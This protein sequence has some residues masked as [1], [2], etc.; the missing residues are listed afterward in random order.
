MNYL[1]LDGGFCTVLQP[2]V[3]AV[4]HTFPGGEPHIK[5]ALPN[6][7]GK[8]A[9]IT[10]TT[11]LNNSD[12]VMQL[13][14]A[15]DA[16][17]RAGWEHVHAVIPYFPAAR[18]D[19][20]M[21]PGEP[22]SLKVYAGLINA[23]HFASVNVFDPHSEVT[24]AL[25]DRVRA[26]PNHAYAAACLRQISEPY[27]LVSPD[28]GALKKIDKLA[29][30][31]GG[32]HEVVE[33]SKRRDLATGALTDFIVYADD[34]AGRA[35]VVVDDICDGGG[36]FLGL[37]KALRARGAGALYFVVSHGIFSKGLDALAEE[38]AQ[39]FTTDSVRE[40]VH[41]QVTQLSLAPFLF[42]DAVPG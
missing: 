3:S 5:L 19:R 21:V 40:I 8:G 31:I 28:G 36:T 26:V 9:E 11:R 20:V 2:A 39:I 32:G 34:L 41:P 12:A 17:K 25:L 4:A 30:Y 10:V 42:P 15:T 38:Y 35:C 6:R 27:F 18:Q 7:P 37:A 14:L 1:H 13:L 23:Q 33:C 29:A 22:L 24:P 16:A